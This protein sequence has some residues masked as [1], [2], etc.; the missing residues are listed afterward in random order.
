MRRSLLLML[1]GT[2][3]LA[4]WSYRKA[5]A[6]VVVAATA[7][8][9]V[10]AVPT[11]APAPRPWPDVDV[12]SALGDPFAVAP[13]PVPI[14]PPAP[15]APPPPPAEPLPPSAPALAHRFF[16]R[17]VGPDG[18]LITLL[19]RTGEPVAISDGQALDDGYVV[20][21]V[22][23]DAVRLVYPPLGV[24]IELPL[25]PPPSEPRSP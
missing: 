22:R 2:A 16:G 24:V 6:P 7:P 15:V 20:E 1:F 17:V 5:P 13:P 18:Q 10:A 11:A 25:P 4:A 14:A 3:A 12:G 9:G 21:A 19:T 23:A 8:A